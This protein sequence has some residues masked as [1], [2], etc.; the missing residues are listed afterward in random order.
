M[1]TSDPKTK[2]SGTAE[3]PAWYRGVVGPPVGDF[4]RA[5][6]GPLK[7]MMAAR[8]P[9]EVQRAGDPPTR[10]TPTLSP[11]LRG[12]VPGAGDSPVG[13]AGGL[14]SIFAPVDG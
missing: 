4:M 8:P 5:Q 9:G 6:D 7:V 1:R 13:V 12:E 2:V 3:P 14:S 11:L 10:V